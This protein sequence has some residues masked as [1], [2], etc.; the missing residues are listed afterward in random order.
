MTSDAAVSL[1]EGLFECI[2]RFHSEL[3]VRSKA[4][5]VAATFEAIQ[6]KSLIS[7]SEED[8]KVSIP[9]LTNLYVEVL[10]TELFEE[11]TRL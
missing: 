1:Q 9:K 10:Q 7:A 3:Q 4:F 5:N 2:D 6:S 11:I 8:W